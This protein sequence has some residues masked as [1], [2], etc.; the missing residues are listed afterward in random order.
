MYWLQPVHVT[1]P[2][3]SS[4][5]ITLPDG[6]TVTLSSRAHMRYQRA[7]G[8]WPF[9]AATE[10]R[11]DLQG[12]AYF[13]VEPSDLSFIV[14]TFNSR[15]EVLGTEF[16]VRSWDAATVVTLTSGRVQVSSTLNEIESVILDT[17]G[18]STTVAELTAAPS[19]PEVVDLEEVL[20]WRTGGFVVNDQPIASVFS[21][22]ERR[23]G[24]EISLQG[25]LP[26]ARLNLFYSK[27]ADAESILRD[28][29][30]TQGLRYRAT[31]RG[32]EV[33]TA[34]LD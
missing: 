17:P 22:L 26:N 31:Q 16:N 32:F 27:P 24:V 5:T 13:D 7:F 15:V 9:M 8:A 18:E 34:S 21:E 2:S 29:C 11:V 1:A 14:E 28:I 10:R 23:F 3:G 19:L 33:F 12:E 30:I 20:V 6:S 25:S 4:L